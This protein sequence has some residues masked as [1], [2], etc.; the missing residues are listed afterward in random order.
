[1]TFQ[2]KISSLLLIGAASMSQAQLFGVSSTGSTN[3]FCQIN[4]STGAATSLFS[5][6]IPG[7][8]NVLALTYIPTT[9]KFI[10]TGQIDAFHSVL[11]EIDANAQTA[12]VVSHG[13]PSNYFEGIEYS[14]AEG[15]LAVS[16][17]PG[18]FY[19]G[20]LALLNDTTYSLIANNAST[21]LPDGDTL[22]VDATGSLNVMDTNNPGL[23]GFMRNRFTNPFGASTIA[24]VGANMYNAVDA[25]FAYK[26][27]EG[28]LF[29]TEQTTLGFVNDPTSTVI[30]TVGGYGANSNGT[31]FR[32]LG[33]AAKPV[34]E[35]ATLAGI[36]LGILG[37]L[38][39]RKRGA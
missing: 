27:D 4:T 24:G 11:I 21:T 22:F 10:T 6:G 33:L 19:S 2:K 5:F 15:G 13:I 17:G 26:T 30:T 36:G 12:T 16:Y 31:A 28:R 7:L 38:R 29:V 18:G 1:M 3:D 9:D 35:P 25:D 14:A 34:P 32:M 39:R 23:N 20:N 37:S 8:T